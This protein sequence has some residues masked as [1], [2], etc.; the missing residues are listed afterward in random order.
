[1]VKAKKNQTT[2][3]SYLKNC[4]NLLDMAKLVKAS[5]SKVRQER[6]LVF[7]QGVKR[8][9]LV[10]KLPELFKWQRDLLSKKDLWVFSFDLE[11]GRMRLVSLDQQTKPSKPEVSSSYGIARDRTGSAVT[12]LLSA[13]ASQ[14][15]EIDQIS[16]EFIDCDASEKLGALVGVSLASYSSQRIV[17]GPSENVPEL[18]ALAIVG[19]E[20]DEL[21]EAQI[22]AESLH[23]SRTL[24]N[25][26]AELL[27]PESFSRFALELIN[28]TS[29][30][31]DFSCEVW[32]ED[33]LAKERFGMHVAVG[34]AAEHP[35]KLVR[36]VYKGQTSGHKSKIKKIAFVGKGVTFDS[37]GLDIKPSSGMRLMKKDM[38]G[39]G[40]V[41]ALARW[42]Q[43]SKYPYPCEFYL[44]LAENAVS[45]PSF[46]P[47]DILTARNGLTVEVGNTDAEGRL[48]LG[49]CLAWLAERSEEYEAVV[50]V[51]TLTGAVKVALGTDTFGFFAND[52]KLAAQLDAAAQVAGEPAWR[53]PLFT[54]MLASMKST[55][56]DL[57]NSSSSGFGGAITAALFL[58][59]FAKN[60]KWAHLDIYGWKDGPK[61]AHAEVG[62]SG[63]ALQCLVEYLKMRRADA[64]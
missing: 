12:A 38:S 17:S 9:A 64:H 33:R 16:I 37:G 40:V 25:L 14:K 7:G 56:A 50:D 43:M 47:G 57:S 51:A 30:S 34:K 42:V 35:S 19:A 21:Q 62:G 29:A 5:T 15:I 22:L 54:P 52:D 53:L 13:I 24:T 39:A 6:L 27:N 11:S 32:D 55:V 41:L 61:D 31:R 20:K 8:E 4:P 23:L 18:P 49:D 36:L 10:K 46:R 1:M 3:L 48:V 44:G 59:R 2:L 58:S 45:S 28:S 60:L 26:P 63:Q